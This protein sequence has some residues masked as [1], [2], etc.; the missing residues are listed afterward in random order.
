MMMPVETTTN[1]FAL[2]PA[3]ELDDLLE[4]A[5]LASGR[6]PETDPLVMALRGSAAAVRSAAVLEP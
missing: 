3:T 4:L 2:V 1:R 6:L 5:R